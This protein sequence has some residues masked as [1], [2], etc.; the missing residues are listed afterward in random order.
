MASSHELNRPHDDAVYS[1]TLEVDN[2]ALTVSLVVQIHRRLPEQ[3][4]RRR[5]PKFR[6]VTNENVEH[7][8]KTQRRCDLVLSA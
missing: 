3:K 1:I 7:L 8:T 4:K 6:Q 2:K 5:W